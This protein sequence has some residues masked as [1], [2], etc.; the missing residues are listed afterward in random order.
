MLFFRRE[1]CPLLSSFP[2][3]RQATL[4]KPLS[5]KSQKIWLEN[6]AVKK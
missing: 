2:L 4:K 5:Q 1:N 6:Q 3:I